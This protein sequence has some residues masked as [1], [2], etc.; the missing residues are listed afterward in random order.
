VTVMWTVMYGFE[1][2]DDVVVRVVVAVICSYLAFLLIVCFDKVAD[3]LRAAN[4]RAAE[5]EERIRAVA[6]RSPSSCT[7]KDPGG[8]QPDSYW[9]DR[10]E[11]LELD[12]RRR[13][14]RTLELHHRVFWLE[15]QLRK[16]PSPRAAACRAGWTKVTDTAA[17]VS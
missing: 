9:K 2:G 6:E 10:A 4:E 7:T 8:S 16:Q 3:A 1:S 14:Q 15:A 5:L 12:L 17:A 13:T 11:A